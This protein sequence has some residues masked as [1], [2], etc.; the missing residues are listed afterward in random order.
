MGIL[1][2]TTSLVYV[3]PSTLSLGVSTRVGNEIGANRLAKIRISMIIYLSCAV[4]L[5]F[6][7][8]LFTTLLRHQWGHLFTTDDKILKLTAIAFPIT[9][10]CEIGN[11][12]Q[13]TGCGVLR[14][15]ARH[16]I[17]ANINLG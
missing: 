1:I 3:F 17:G 15:S 13:T 5:G 16:T 2:Q 11:C 12:P 7:A 6:V 4:T 9:R 14:G 8:W 10:L